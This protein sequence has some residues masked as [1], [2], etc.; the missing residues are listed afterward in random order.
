MVRM[1]ICLFIYDENLKYLRNC[2]GITFY[3]VINVYRNK[4]VKCWVLRIRSLKKKCRE[5]DLKGGGWRV[6]FTILCFF[7]VVAVFIGIFCM[8]FWNLCVDFCF[9]ILWEGLGGCFFCDWK[10]CGFFFIRVI[11]CFF[12]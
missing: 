10:F 6:K 2:M 4:M 7:C 1:F 8:F 9:S 12:F 5:S 3:Y 11:F